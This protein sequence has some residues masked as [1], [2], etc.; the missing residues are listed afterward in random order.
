MSRDE[1]PQCR[2]D[3]AFSS[4]G[5]QSM[6]QNVREET[7]K[8]GSVV[9]ALEPTGH[10]W[11]VLGQYL[12]DQNQAYVLIYPL[13]FAK[14][15]EVNHLNKAKADRLDAIRCRTNPGNSG[16]GH[17]SLTGEET[18]CANLGTESPSFW[19]NGILFFGIS[20]TI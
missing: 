8:R 15:R 16:A 4:E 12:E 13:V 20:C 1:K 5:F 11:M 7:G 17:P 19:R 10:Y 2:F 6:L 3:V 14:S 18:S 9:F